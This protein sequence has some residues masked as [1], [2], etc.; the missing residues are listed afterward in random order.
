M[1]NKVYLLVCQNLEREMRMIRQDDGFEPLEIV[2]YPA[3]CGRPA[4]SWEDL[5][6]LLPPER[7]PSDL[8]VV[9]GGGCL[10]KLG[11][12]PRELGACRVYPTDQCFEFVAGRSMVATLNQQGAYLLTPGWLALWRQRLKQWGFDRATA[13]DFF[14]ESARR[15]V[16]LDTGVDPNSAEKLKEFSDY[17]GRPGQIVPV[18][19]DFLRL[20]LS[21]ILGRWRLDNQAHATLE[22]LAEAN[23]K[24]GDYAMVSDLAGRLASSKSET[25]VIENLFELYTMLFAPASLVFLSVVHAEPGAVHSRPSPLSDNQAAIHRLMELAEDYAWTKSGKGF[26]LRFKGLDGTLGVLEIEGITFPE[27]KQHYLN[28]ALGLAHTCSLAISNARFYETLQNNLAQLQDALAKVK[29]LSG[30]LPI[31]ASCKKIR[32]DQGYWNQIETY[33][34]QHS[35]AQFTHGICPDCIQKLYSEFTLPLAPKPHP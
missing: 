3:K 12:P 32:D 19:L 29:T 25:D 7:T 9:L 8:F 27:H 13:C 20:T 31:C 34:Q 4:M 30:L 35:G 18:E 21:N 16:L 24:L 10:G 1:T 5:R 2:V 28:L 23:R 14:S 17:V 26:C 11:P 6:L 33:V 22:A 15:L